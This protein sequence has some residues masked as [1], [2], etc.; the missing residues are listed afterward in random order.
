VEQQHDVKEADDKIV[1]G[2]KVEKHDDMVTAEMNV[3][4]S[5]IDLD[6]K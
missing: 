5:V 4:D 2:D 1:I 3:D 6:V